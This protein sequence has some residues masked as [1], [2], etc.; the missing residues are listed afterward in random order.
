MKVKTLEEQFREDLET[1]LDRWECPDQFRQGL[2]EY[3]V[4]DFFEVLKEAKE[5][6][7]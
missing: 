4:D 5:N 6:E 7:T 3:V 1:F 2:M